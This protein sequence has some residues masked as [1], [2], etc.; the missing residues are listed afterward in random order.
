MV[1]IRQQ[2]KLCE[3]WYQ[4][5]YSGADGR[6]ALHQHCLT[7]SSTPKHIYVVF[8][9]YKANVIIL[10]D[11]LKIKNVI[12]QKKKVR[13]L[14]GEIIKST[15]R[16]QH[17]F[18]VTDRKKWKKIT[19]NEKKENYRRP[20]QHYQPTWLNWHLQNTVI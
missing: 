9:G 7:P 15:N 1:E 16:F 4:E 13:E 12:F 14:K 2:K 5:S 20:E 18:P 6:P 8:I 3:Q 10:R 11:S 17:P 19:K